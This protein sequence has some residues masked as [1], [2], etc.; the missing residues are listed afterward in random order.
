MKA[1]FQV[2]TGPQEGEEFEVETGAVCRV[3]KSSEWS[4][5]ALPEDDAISIAHFSVECDAEQCTLID[6]NSRGGTY[7]NG[8][9]VTRTVLKHGDRIVIGG[10]VLE[11]R[12][13]GA[14]E[15]AEGDKAQGEGETDPAGKLLEML[16]ASPEPLYVLLDGSRDGKVVDLISGGEQENLSLFEGKAGVD[17]QFFAPYLVSVPPGSRLLEEITR[18]GWGNSWGYF[19]TSHAPLY[20]VRQHLRQFLFVKDEDGKELYFRFYDPRILRL[21]LPTCTKTETAAF[22]GPVLRFLIESEDAR[23]LLVFQQDERGIAASAFPLAGG[24]T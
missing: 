15:E 21:Y 12:F 4:Q 8:K 2:R 18:E 7:V 11:V 19:L 1:I 16:N 22:F 6:L 20:D 10:T 3:G 24:K 9:R 13:E 23:S 17:L 14:E 5:F